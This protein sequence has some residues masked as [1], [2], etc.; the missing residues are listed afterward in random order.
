M[1]ADKGMLKAIHGKSV[2]YVNIHAH[3]KGVCYPTPTSIESVGSSAALDN[4]PY[5]SCFAGGVLG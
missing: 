1:Y 3:A 5:E 2:L 4:S